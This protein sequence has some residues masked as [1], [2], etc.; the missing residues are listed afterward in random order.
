MN[1]VTRRDFIKYAT[2]GTAAAATVLPGMTALSADNVVGAN[3]RIN[4]GIIGVGGKGKGH[5]GAFH[6]HPMSRIV[7]VSDADAEHMKAA[8]GAAQHQDMRKLLEMKDVDA[9]VIATPNHWHSLAAIWAM[10]AGKHVY[11]EK[12]VS[13]NI[14]EGRKMVE[15]ARKYKRL[16]QAGTQHRSCP[17][18]IAAARDIKAGKY[19]KVIW[20]HCSK[21]GA[22]KPIGKIDK[23]IPVPASVDYDLWAGPAPKTPIM[24]QRFHYDW[25][26]QFN[27]GDGEMGNWGPHYIDDLRH[28][29]GWDDVPTSVVSAGNRFWDDNGDTPNMQFACMEHKG[30]KVV[31]DIRNMAD[32][33]GGSGGAVYL[34]SRGGNYIMCEKGYIKISRGGGRGYDHDNKVIAKYKGDSGRGHVSNFLKAV[35]ANDPGMLNADIEVGHQSTVMCHLANIAWRVGREASVEEVRESFKGHEDAVNTLGSMLPQL[36]FNKVNLKK[37]PFVLGPTLTYDNKAERFTGAHAK[38]AN[39]YV[40]PGTRK[41]FEING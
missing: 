18:P 19:G 20:V 27:W 38:K 37:T 9:A 14:W 29:L 4:V 32:P 21:L 2:A 5:L 30:V 6:H 25:H 39:A 34:G 41:G 40:R 28:I 11:V 33:K 16:C 35:K 8:P 1:R 7:A 17:A 3:E 26:W 15:A 22:R 13:H 12:P 10:Q 24:R 31:V 36:E 23:P